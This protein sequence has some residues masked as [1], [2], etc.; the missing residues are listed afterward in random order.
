MIRHIIAC[1]DECPKCLENIGIGKTE[2]HLKE[3]HPETAHEP[4]EPAK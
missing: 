3:C 1:C 2:A 4:K